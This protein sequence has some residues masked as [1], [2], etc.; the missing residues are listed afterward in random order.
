MKQIEKRFFFKSVK[1]QTKLGINH[2]LNI[3]RTSLDTG[4]FK[5]LTL[6]IYLS[7]LSLSRKDPNMSFLYF[8]VFPQ[9]PFLLHLPPRLSF[10]FRSNSGAPSF[11][12]SA[13][14]LWFRCQ[15]TSHRSPSSAREECSECDHCAGFCLMY[16]P[17][18]VIY[19]H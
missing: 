4:F 2:I 9:H 13:C 3:L 8:T 1:I 7:S 11:S 14:E 5:T 10:S 6:F 15:V 17:K 12:L 18:W 19:H 16:M